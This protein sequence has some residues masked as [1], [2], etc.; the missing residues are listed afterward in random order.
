MT[1]NEDRMSSFVW[2]IG[3]GVATAVSILAV[4]LFVMFVVVVFGELF[5]PGDGF[6]QE[7]VGTLGFL[8]AGICIVFEMTLGRKSIGVGSSFKYRPE[9]ITIAGLVVVVEGVLYLV[10]LT[11]FKGL[12][13]SLIT[14]GLLVVGLGLFDHRN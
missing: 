2:R 5:S 4:Y 9:L 7:F 10:R 1:A 11:G 3:E 6:Q 12:G 13:V 14:T 8:V